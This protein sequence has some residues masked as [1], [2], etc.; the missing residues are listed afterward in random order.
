MGKRTT[1][2][3]VEISIP[4]KEYAKL[5]K[6]MDEAF[7]GYEATDLMHRT[8]EKYMSGD[9]HKNYVEAYYGKPRS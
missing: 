1:K 5:I 7:N 3:M 8:L 6:K 2:A 9:S 4:A